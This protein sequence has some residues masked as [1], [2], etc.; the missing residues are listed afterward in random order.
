MFLTIWKRFC[1]EYKL[2]SSKNKDTITTGLGNAYLRTLRLPPLDMLLG[3]T[4]K[5]K[6]DE[7]LFP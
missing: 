1:Q 7:V 4:R 2:T 5:P 3:I 6:T